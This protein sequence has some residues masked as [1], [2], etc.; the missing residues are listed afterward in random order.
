MAKEDL[1][2]QVVAINVK[3][4]T[5]YL[6]TLLFVNYIFF[7]H[8]LKGLKHTQIQILHIKVLQIFENRLLNI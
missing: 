1:S 8:N 6:L 7:I 5:I 4:L 3:N 2:H